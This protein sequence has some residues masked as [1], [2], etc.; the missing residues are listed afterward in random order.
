ML[1]AQ[2]RHAQIVGHTSQTNVNPFE[3]WLAKE[4]DLRA[5]EL[6]P[7]KRLGARGAY[8]DLKGGEGE[9]EIWVPGGSKQ[10]VNWQAG[11]VIG[12][13]L[14]AW[15][16]HLNRGATPARFV[17]MTNAP[18]VIDLSHNEDFIYR[19]GGLLRHGAGAHLG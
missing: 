2:Q 12:P 13:P 3:E 4:A 14:N 19:T 9:T 6:G 5:L 8:L 18:V 11:S 1:A 16:Q 7:W 17:S 10:S 15:R